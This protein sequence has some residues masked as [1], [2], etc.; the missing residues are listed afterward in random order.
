MPHQAW[1][2]RPN[3]KERKRKSTCANT[4]FQLFY[5]DCLVLLV[6]GLLFLLSVLFV[7][8]SPSN[9]RWHSFSFS[10][11][12]GQAHTRRLALVSNNQKE[13][14]VPKSMLDFLKSSRINLKTVHGFSNHRNLVWDTKLPEGVLLCWKGLNGNW[15]DTVWMQSLFHSRWWSAVCTERKIPEISQMNKQACVN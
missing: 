4:Q 11:W 1:D 10:T 3:V 12:V 6:V 7:H 8:K 14:L 2:S 9:V 15:C 13:P 5:F